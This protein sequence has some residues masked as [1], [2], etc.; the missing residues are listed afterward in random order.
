[1]GDR[2]GPIE[3][4]TTTSL[5]EPGGFEPSGLGTS[6]SSRSD[7]R[8]C[9][10]LKPLDGI[11]GGGLISSS[12]IVVVLDLNCR[13][14]DLSVDPVI[15]VGISRDSPGSCLGPRRTSFT[16]WPC[17][18]GP[19]IWPSAASG[20]ATPRMKRATIGRRIG[21]LVHSIAV[22]N[23]ARD[24]RAV[25]T[26]VNVGSGDEAPWRSVGIRTIEMM[27]TIKPKQKI[28]MSRYLWRWSKGITQRG[29]IGIEKMIRS[30]QTLILEIAVPKSLEFSLVPLRR[31]MIMVKYRVTT[32]GEFDLQ[33][34]SVGTQMLSKYGLFTT[35][36]VGTQLSAYRI[37]CPIIHR[38]EKKA[39]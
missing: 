32:T 1:M 14:A 38:K 37:F 11:G 26:L 3:D 15:S 7:A 29:R 24:H 28:P 36:V 33:T 4:L 34:G 17:P 8:G 10:L 13:V 9:H 27:T 31:R 5:L 35:P 12:S 19:F 30:V 25:W 2:R 20:G 23:S 6:L 39:K 22:S 16:F 21:R 18:C